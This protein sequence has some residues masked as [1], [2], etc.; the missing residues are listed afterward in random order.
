MVLRNPANEA[1]NFEQI[2][3]GLHSMQGLISSKLIRRIYVVFEKSKKAQLT[4]EVSI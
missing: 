3:W 4:H 2:S 1:L